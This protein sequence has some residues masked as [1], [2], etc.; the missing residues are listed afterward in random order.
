MIILYII[1]GYTEAYTEQDTEIW[2][3]LYFYLCYLN[4]NNI[5]KFNLT[6]TILAKIVVT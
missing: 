1:A 2:S 5:D 6:I 4:G 3:W